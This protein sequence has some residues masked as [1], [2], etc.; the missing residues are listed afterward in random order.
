MWEDVVHITV[1]MCS[2]LPPLLDTCLVRVHALKSLEVMSDQLRCPSATDEGSPE[3]KEEKQE[4][5]G[6]PSYMAGRESP[7]RMALKS[8]F[9][10]SPEMEAHLA[11]GKSR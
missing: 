1:P 6:S 10:I 9:G 7:G 4:G 2:W 11:V 5:P 3:R 8:L